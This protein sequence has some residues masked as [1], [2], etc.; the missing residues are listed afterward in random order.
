MN[1]NDI[2]IK[3]YDE[4]FQFFCFVGNIKHLEKNLENFPFGLL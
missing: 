4:T 1:K 3:N 2:I